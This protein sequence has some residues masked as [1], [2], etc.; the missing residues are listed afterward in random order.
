M[1]SRDEDSVDLLRLHR[2]ILLLQ[3]LN[4]HLGLAIGTQPPQLSVLAHLSELVTQGI[5]HGVGQW[6]GILGL[7]TGIS[8][9]NTLVTSTKVHVILANMDSSSNIWALLV[10]AHDDL[11]RLVT[12]P[13]AIH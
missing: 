6:H 13:L 3:V 2:A 1:L 7:I 10:D 8:E 12:D 9:H 5:G 4:G 11:A